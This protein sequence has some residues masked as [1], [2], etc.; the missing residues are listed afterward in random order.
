MADTI[1][2]LAQVDLTTTALTDVYTVPGAT[3]ATISSILVCNRTGSAVTFRISFAPAGAVDATSQYGYYDVSVSDADT[4][5][6]T[7]GVTLATTDVLRAKASTADAL[8]IQVFG[9]QIT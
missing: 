5:G 4:V 1:K 6:L 7:I 2:I 8:T 9:V 3:S